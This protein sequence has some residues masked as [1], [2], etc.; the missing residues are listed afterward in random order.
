MPFLKALRTCC[1]SASDATGLDELDEGV[2]GEEAMIKHS[3]KKIWGRDLM[4]FS[5]AVVPAALSC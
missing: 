2:E 4:V 5:V 1:D 3:V